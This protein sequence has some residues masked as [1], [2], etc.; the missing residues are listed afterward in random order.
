MLQPPVTQVR[1]IAFSN[2]NFDIFFQRIIQP[3]QPPRHL[4]HQPH[5]QQTSVIQ[6][7]FQHRQ[8]CTVPFVLNLGPLKM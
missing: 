7:N 3:N 8:V 6:Q 4:H 1:Y 2:W 5:V